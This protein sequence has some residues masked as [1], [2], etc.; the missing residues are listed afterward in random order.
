MSRKLIRF[1]WAIKKL[2]R[3]KANF[4]I[5]EGFLSELLFENIKIIKILESEANQEDAKDKFNRV[6]MLVENEKGEFIIVEVQNQDELDYFQRILYGTSKLL[7][8]YIN[9]GEAYH[10][11]KKVISVNIVYFD[12]GHGEDYLYR[13]QTIFVGMRKND[14]LSLNE[15][16]KEY[17]GKEK[18]ENIF[19]EYYLIKA[20]NFDDIAKDTLDEWI[21]FLKNSEIKDEF[22][23]KGLKEAKETLNVMQLS[24]E[25]YQK[26]R[27]DMDNLSYHNSMVD[28]NKFIGKF[29]AKKELEEMAGEIKKEQAKIIALNLLKNNIPIEII[30]TATGLSEE[31]I[32]TL[33]REIKEKN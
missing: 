20:N 33:Q 11:L 3:N 29:E 24:Q 8:E 12:L 16:Q 18:I 9:L 13:G 19:P 7:T 31:E 32:L 2:L 17:F 23:A 10:Q 28:S 22:K 4:G 25:D 21:Y 5:L 30:I 1:D 15:K 6:D 14:V 27:K 26:Y